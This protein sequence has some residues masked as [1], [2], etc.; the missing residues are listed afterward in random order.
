M[1]LEGEDAELLR[2]KKELQEIEER[3]MYKKAFIAVKT[4]GLLE[5]K[6]SDKQLDTNQDETLKERVKAILQRHP[7]SLIH[8]VKTNHLSDNNAAKM[9]E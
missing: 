9:T 6:S 7:Y 5:K 4:I 3:I 1:V 8:K 2:R